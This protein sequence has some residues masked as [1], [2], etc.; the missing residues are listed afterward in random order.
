MKRPY[1]YLSVC[2]LLLFGVV[3]FFY[4][5]GWEAQL[6][7]KIKKGKPPA[8]AIEQIREDLKS[9]AKQGVRKELLDQVMAR[10]TG[11]LFFVR[12][13]IKGEEVLM[14]NQG[15]LSPVAASRALLIQ[16]AL[17]SLAKCTPLPEVDFV[18]TVHDALMAGDFPGPVFA[19]AKDGLNSRGI[20]FPD[21]EALGGNLK[22]LEE[23]RQGSKK[24]PWD[25]KIA[26]GYWRGATTGR[27]FSSRDFFEL[28][29]TKVVALSLKHSESIDAKF[30]QLVQCADP[31][32]VQDGFA[33]YFG[34]GIPVR[35]HLAYKYQLLLDGNS[36]SYTR[37]YW[38]LF[39][40]CPIFKHAST[41]VQWY[42]RGLQ[43]NVHYIPLQSDCSDLVEK[44]EWAKLHDEEVR[45]IGNEA[46]RFAQENLTH[47]D[48][49][50]Y[51]YLLL[52]EYSK[53]CA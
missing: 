49:L 36:C 51:V 30:T 1:F 13:Q 28:L 37:A 18:L 41:H 23:V 31:E 27:G 53:L 4:P 21:A 32:N 34:K 35:K 22:E 8:W 48:I 47:I 10:D 14:I 17:R 25:K 6:V 11:E 5:T 2:I 50:Y 29:R 44:I 15:K 43:P 7:R 38:Q 46:Y 40:G 26:K 12:Y 33:S 3:F 42:Y 45:A 19:F 9:F 24:F 20:L 52:L 39:S 16:E